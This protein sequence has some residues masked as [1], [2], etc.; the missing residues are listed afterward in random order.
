MLTEGVEYITQAFFVTKNNNNFIQ[1]KLGL[2]S[3]VQHLPGTTALLNFRTK[4]GLGEE[5][6]W[7]HPPEENRTHNY[8]VESQQPTY[9]LA[10]ATPLFVLESNYFNLIS[11]RKLENLSNEGDA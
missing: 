11:N 8:S 2:Q 7:Y 5:Y 10:T 9:P 3:P 1:V 6:S 4:G